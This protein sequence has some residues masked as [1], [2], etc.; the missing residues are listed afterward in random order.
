MDVNDEAAV[1]FG[2]EI[3]M[4]LFGGRILVV[5]ILCGRICVGGFGGGIWRA[6]LYGRICMSGFVWAVFGGGNFLWAVFGG[7]QGRYP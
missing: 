1:G 6:V 2:E 5:K 7:F 3:Y 4:A